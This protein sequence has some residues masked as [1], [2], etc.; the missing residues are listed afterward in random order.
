MRWEGW[1]MGGEYLRGKEGEW[2]RDR[3]EIEGSNIM[4]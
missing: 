1:M 2:V 4:K 3:G